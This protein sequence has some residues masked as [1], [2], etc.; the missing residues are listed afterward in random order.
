MRRS[1]RSRDVSGRIAPSLMILPI[2]SSAL[3]EIAPTWAISFVVVQGFEIFFSSSV[4]AMTAYAMKGDL[5]KCMAAGMDD[6]IS[7]P[8]R[9]QAL[10]DTLRRWVPA[11][12]TPR[13]PLAHDARALNG[14]PAPAKREHSLRR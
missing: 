3:A 8:M 13:E 11:L 9:Y 2:A 6:Y 14:T 10:V 12:S 1:S 4:I 7:K 5:E